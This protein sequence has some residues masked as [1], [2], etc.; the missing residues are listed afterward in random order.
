M[1]VGAASSASHRIYFQD[2][3]LSRR[4][5]RSLTCV[6][7]RASV[8]AN[9]ISLRAV[10]QA[11]LSFFSRD[12]TTLSQVRLKMHSD[13]VLQVEN[14]T[15]LLIRIQDASVCMYVLGNLIDSLQGLTISYSSTR[16]DVLSTGVYA[17]RRKAG[18][19]GMYLHKNRWWILCTHV[20]I[21][22]VFVS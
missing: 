11:E 15:Y 21:A 16:S 1:Y 18:Y 19:V 3:T 22:L 7:S 6:T 4:Q 8:Y 10:L 14:G 20:C 5:E 9:T 12:E 2:D 17:T 13:G